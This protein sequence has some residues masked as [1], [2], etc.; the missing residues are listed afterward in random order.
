MHVKS[1][2]PWLCA[3]DEYIFNSLRVNKISQNNML[4]RENE[5]ILFPADG[6]KHIEQG[7]VIPS[8]SS[9]SLHNIQTGQKK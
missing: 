1:M 5:A 3:D 4:D 2:P 6:L 7:A 8:L 9:I